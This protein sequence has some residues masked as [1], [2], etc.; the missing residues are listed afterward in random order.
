MKARFFMIPV[1]LAVFLTMIPPSARAASGIEQ[2][3]GSYA[4]I[5]GGGLGY[6]IRTGALAPIPC[7]SQ[8]T[9][10]V[11]GKNEVFTV[12]NDTRFDALFAFQELDGKVRH[13]S[14][15]GD[16]LHNDCTRGYIRGTAVVGE[17]GKQNTLIHTFKAR[18]RRV[19]K[20][21]QDGVA[22]SYWADN[23]ALAAGVGTCTYTRE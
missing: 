17:I 9:V 21:V 14:N 18:Q 23:P 10:K 1:G 20:S 13:C 8:I 7:P 16:P 6:D 3:A 4:K 15:S 2:L 5:S 11:T 19:L 12:S 22:L